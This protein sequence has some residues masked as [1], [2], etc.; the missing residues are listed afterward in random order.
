VPI[1]GDGKRL[2][3]DKFSI[4]NSKIIEECDNNGDN[5]GCDSKCKVSSGWKCDGGDWDK[6]DICIK[7]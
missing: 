5:E 6:P 7:I 2:R 4:F 1:C 3:P